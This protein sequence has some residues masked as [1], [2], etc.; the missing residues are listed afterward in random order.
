MKVIIAIILFFGLV[1]YLRYK[2]Y[3]ARI[4]NKEKTGEV[5]ND[6]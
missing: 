2:S 4:R 5:K 6:R 3:V 1:F